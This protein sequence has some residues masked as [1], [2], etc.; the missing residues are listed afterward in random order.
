MDTLGRNFQCESLGIILNRLGYKYGLMLVFARDRTFVSEVVTG[1][2][3][4]GQSNKS[5]IYSQ[6]CNA[7]LR[8]N[9]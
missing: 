3:D 5:K 9:K 2:E 6:K 1:V 7:D 4:T 8:S